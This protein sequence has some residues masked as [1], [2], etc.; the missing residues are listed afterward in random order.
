MWMVE[1]VYEIQRQQAKR[2]G[3]GLGCCGAG[4]RRGAD[5]RKGNGV[6][7]GARGRVWF[8]DP[9]SEPSELSTGQ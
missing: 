6:E 5:L 9:S 8:N 1:R 2:G 4:K 7:T 3:Y